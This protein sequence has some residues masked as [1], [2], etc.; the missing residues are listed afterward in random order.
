[1]V[2]AGVY[3][4][5]VLVLS[6]AIATLGGGSQLAV[7]GATLAVAGLFHPAR[8]R[9]QHTVDK[10]FSRSRYDAE[11]T[12]EAFALRLRDEADLATLATDLQAVVASTMRPRAVSLWLSCRE[13]GREIDAAQTHRLRDPHRTR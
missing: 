4:G 8:R 13:S 10:R 9:I 11:R 12:V 2:L 7:A 6:P 1:M 5:V 3:G